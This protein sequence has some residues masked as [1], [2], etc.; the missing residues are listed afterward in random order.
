M[1]IQHEILENNL[2]RTYSDNSLKI[3]QTYDRLGQPI[4]EYAIYDEAVDILINGEPRY[5]YVETDEPIEV[6]QEEEDN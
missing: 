1:A 4:S 3:K 5:D 2:V 6:E